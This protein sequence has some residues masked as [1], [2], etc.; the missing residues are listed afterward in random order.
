M[1]GG[2]GE[3]EDKGEKVEK[4]ERRGDRK[5]GKREDEGKKGKEK[6]EGRW[7][8]GEMTFDRDRIISSSHTFIHPSAT[9]C[10]KQM[11]ERIVSKTIK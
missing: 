11:D 1:D 4:G 9:A 5:E 7:K 10:W 3:R 6:R 2:G 8:N